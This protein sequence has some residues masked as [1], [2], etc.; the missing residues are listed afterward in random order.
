MTVYFGPGAMGSGVAEVMGLLNGVNYPNAIGFKTLFTKVF[1]ILFAVCGG[2][3]IGKEGPL[4]H[5]GANIGAMC[6]YLPF[7]WSLYLQN[8]VQKRNLMAAGGAAGVSVAFG[9]PIGGALF[10]YE[11]S[12]PNTFWNFGMLWK[13][14]LSTSIACFTLA[15]LQSLEIGSPLSLSDS[16]AIKF[17]EISA[18]IQNTLLD[19]PAAIVLG[20]LCG[21]LGAAFIN[22]TLWSGKIRK[23][24]VNTNVKKVLECMFMAFLTA[25]AF[26]CV[27]IA[28]KN[29][30]KPKTG[31]TEEE[32]AEQLRFV[33]PEDQYNPLAT[34]IF[35]TEGGTIRQ[36]FRYPEIIANAAE[37]FETGIQTVIN[38]SIY[39]VL[40]YVFFVITYG[41]WVPAGVFIPGMIIGCTL[42]LLYLEMMMNGFNVELINLGGQSY[43]IMGASAMLSS[44]T[45]L[46]Y[47]LAVLM[48]ETAQ[49]INYFLQIMITILVAHG[50]AKRFN[51]SLYEYSIRGK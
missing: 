15:I 11:I 32:R 44:Y 19:L 18:D 14:F 34:L 49:A 41:V 5:I 23:Q 25:T 28:R 40:W 35:N 51:R 8:D 39:L 27:V 47:S 43:L 48:M 6:C 21:L 26:Y 38:L 46:T 31:A 50:I 45:R 30:C 20:I 29:E 9:A 37:D 33:C 36:F 3:C 12:R 16:G 10:A 7:K 22:F 4:V 2:L 24:Y 42:G 17:G 1:G 13:V